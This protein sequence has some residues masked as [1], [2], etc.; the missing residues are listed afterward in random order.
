MRHWPDEF[1]KSAIPFGLL[2][3]AV[4]H[5]LNGDRQIP[6]AERH[7][8]A[9]RAGFA[10]QDRQ[11]MPGIADQLISPKA[12]G[13]F[14]DH[15]TFGHDPHTVGRAAHRDGAADLPTWRDLLHRYH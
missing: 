13:M 14:G 12:A 3:N 1:D 15:S 6:L 10:F 2:E 8:V 11:I 5:A 7:A 9:Q 4:A